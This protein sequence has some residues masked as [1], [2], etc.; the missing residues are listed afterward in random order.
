MKPTSTVPLTGMYSGSATYTTGVNP[1][2]PET[3][4][5]SEPSDNNALV[6]IL[7]IAGIALVCLGI[8]IFY[9]YKAK[10]A[11]SK[12]TLRINNAD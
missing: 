3:P 5:P 10:A 6:W 8:A 12:N 4:S 2:N 7:V 1:F 9:F 11:D